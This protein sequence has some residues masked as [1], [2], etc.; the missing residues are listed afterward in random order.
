M[1]VFRQIRFRIDIHDQVREYLNGFV[2]FE[3]IHQLPNPGRLRPENHR[4]ANDCYLLLWQ[5]KQRIFNFNFEMPIN[6]LAEGFVKFVTGVLGITVE[7]IGGRQVQQFALWMVFQVLH[8]VQ[9][10]PGALK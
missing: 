8:Q 9:S 1:V 6:A 4:Q 2:L 5:P 7:Y 3:M 10:H